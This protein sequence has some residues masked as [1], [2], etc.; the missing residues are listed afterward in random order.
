MAIINQSFDKKYSYSTLKA[1]T[2]F[3][4]VKHQKTN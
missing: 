2:I 3:P 1:K 4:S